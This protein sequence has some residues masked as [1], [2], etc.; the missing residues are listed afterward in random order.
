MHALVLLRLWYLVEVGNSMN[1]R[2]VGFLPYIGIPKH[3]TH[4]GFS[5]FPITVIFFNV[6]LISDSEV[7]EWQVAI[8]HSRILGK[9]CACKWLWHVI[10]NF[11]HF[12]TKE[13]AKQLQS[14]SS[15]CFQLLSKFSL[16]DKIRWLFIHPVCLWWSSTLWTTG[17]LRLKLSASMNQET[18][19]N[20]VS[21]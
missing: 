17:S 4:S 9:P 5:Y 13:Q 19:I 14:W 2:I 1:A 6:I 16:E 10:A 11:L 12:L 7:H 18:S 3:D 20:E 8:E 15:R 21:I